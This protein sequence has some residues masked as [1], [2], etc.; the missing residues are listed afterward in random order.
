MP[1]FETNQKRFTQ[2]E[3][4]PDMKARDDVDQYY[5]ALET[6]TNVFPGA[7]G[8][9]SRR[10]ALEF[11]DRVLGDL[12]LLTGGTI[13][14][15]APNGGTAGNASDQDRSTKL[16]TTTG[17]STTNPYVVV[18]YDLGSSKNIGTIYLYDAKISSGSADDWAV[19][20]STNDI[21]W[22]TVEASSYVG[23]SAGKV[24]LTTTAKDFS[25]RVHGSYQ[26][27]RFARVGNDDEGSTTAEISGLDVVT[28][29]STSNV[30]CIDFEFNKDQT[31]KMIVSDKNIAIY[32][33]TTY[34]IDI[35]VE[36]LTEDEIPDMD[37]EDDADTLIIFH[38]DLETITLQRNG[39]NDIWVLSTVSWSNIPVHAYDGAS[40]SN[41]A[42]SV[43]ADATTGFVTLTG[44]GTS[45][46]SAYVNQYINYTGSSTFGRIFVTEYVS[47]T[48]IKGNVIETLS[49]TGSIST[50]DWEYESGYEEI[51]SATRGYPRRGKTYENR[52]WVD[53]GKSRPSVLYG[54]KRGVTQAQLFDFDFGT[55]QDDEA[56]GP[57]TGGYDVIEHIYDGPNL[58][59]LTSSAEYIVPQTFGEPITP[60][61]AA[62]RRQTS[63][64]SEANLRP[65]EVDGGVIYVQRNKASIQELI[66]TDQSDQKYGSNII[67]LLSTHLIENT[68]DFAVNTGNSNNEASYIMAV[69]SNGNLSVAAALRTEGVTAFVR[70]TT[71]GDFKCCGSDDEDMF[72]I[73]QRGSINYLERFNFTMYTDSGVY[74]TEGLP[75][76]ILTES[77]NEIDLQHFVDIGDE[78]RVIADDVVLDNDTLTVASIDL[79]TSASSYAEIGL[80]F[81]PTIKDL[82]ASLLTNDGRSVLGHKINL[83]EV[84]L[85]LKDTKQVIIN[86]KEIDLTKYDSSGTVT[87]LIRKMGWRG[88]DDDGQITI[89]QDDPVSLTL[90]SIKKVMEY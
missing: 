3:L 85:R 81:N 39:D 50:G 5:G 60:T 59:V 10:P 32:Q 43:S 15:T 45:F 38:E 53:G 58:M 67:S 88:W 65:A 83:R 76:Q 55:A 74:V 71:E 62:L 31:Y 86:G 26:Y 12:T 30:K 75:A 66:L 8:Q 6:A 25:F 27:V 37:W 42:G 20:V 64:G 18:H 11:I 29:S 36:D 78:V 57:L 40:F 51:W 2:G 44:S 35:Y 61:N 41:P 24:T 13:T 72:F 33:G 21:T 34:L 22:V 28:E 9:L 63:K 89:T 79:G 56:I 70:Q 69:Q 47:G 77:A 87:G 23:D 80:D 49:G 90:Q 4:D 19:Q 48:E 82:P 84:V 68:V 7:Q 52:L 16:T 1:V 54:S 46:T 17:I 73:I 14:E